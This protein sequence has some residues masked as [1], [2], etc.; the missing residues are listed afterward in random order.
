MTDNK[1]RYH[2][3]LRRMPGA[4]ENAA[5]IAA[6]LDQE[7]RERA[8][9]AAL[10]EREARLEATATWRDLCHLLTLAH[11]EAER[12]LK[13]AV[14]G[15]LERMAGLREGD[16]EAEA[17]ALIDRL[18]RRGAAAYMAARVART[19][20]DVAQA[21]GG[22]GVALDM[23][24][25]NPA[26]NN[27]HRAW[28]AVGRVAAALAPDWPAWPDLVPDDM[29]ALVVN[30]LALAA[31]GGGLGALRDAAFLLDYS[32]RTLPV[33]VWAGPDYLRQADE[34]TLA[35]WLAEAS[36]GVEALTAPLFADV[37]RLGPD[38]ER[39]MSEVM[40]WSYQVSHLYETR[41]LVADTLAAISRAITARPVFVPL[42]K[43]PL[44]GHTTQTTVDGPGWPDRG[45]LGRD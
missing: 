10:G 43:T 39:A 42:D 25:T 2:A 35:A 19:A 12:G 23:G 24:A 22:G 36:Q 6:A 40:V 8:M 17:E 13:Q 3:V 5:F 7:D 33:E 28:V 29:T 14:F 38:A 41:R 44:W 32:L 15:Q 37:A 21:S 1:H 30:P 11:E 34:A 16:L 31:L 27:L 45:T 26:L 18:G 20:A 4:A 9:L